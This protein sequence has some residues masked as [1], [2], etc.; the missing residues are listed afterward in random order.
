MKGDC[1]DVLRARTAAKE[2]GFPVAVLCGLREAG[3]FEVRH[4]LLR[5]P[6]FD[7]GD[8]MRF[9]ERLSALIPDES[10]IP[11]PDKETTLGQVLRTSRYTACEKVKVIQKLLDNGI[12][13]I[14][15]TDGSFRGLQ[16]PQS[17]LSS[18][19]RFQTD[20]EGESV[21]TCAEAA[22]ALN[23]DVDA[24]RALIRLEYLE[25][26]KGSR[27][28]RITER[29]I[30][31]FGKAFVRL[32]SVA[33]IVHSSSR[34]L[35]AVC[36]SNVIDVVEIRIRGGVQPFVRRESLTLIVRVARMSGRTSTSLSGGT[37]ATNTRVL[38]PPRFA[39]S[40]R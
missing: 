3:V 24:V 37:K 10:R 26:V 14:G 21:V 5:L 8:V 32:S 30:R 9:K 36:K 34:R 7:R 35:M 16:I 2:I 22:T 1:R 40:A 28:W 6:G 4:P 11:S 23:C 13:V 12:S 38:A 25:G 17:Q 20:N 15:S 31:E 33:D 19:R 29:S 18:I 27:S 39:E